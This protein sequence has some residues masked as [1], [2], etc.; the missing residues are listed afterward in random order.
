[1]FGVSASKGKEELALVFDI[2]SSS[3]GGALFYRE[4]TKIPKI[5]F[6]VRESIPI[7]KEMD[8][9]AFLLS[10]VKSLDNVA[11]KICSKGLG[12]P[13][14]VFCVLSSPWHVSQTRVIH[15][16]K[17]T[18][19]NFTT[20]LAD[21]L[22]EKEIKLFESEH[23]EKYMETG[24]KIRPIELKNMQTTLNGY[25]T[26]NPLGQKASTLSM[27]LFVSMSPEQFLSKIEEAIDRHFSHLTIK[28]SSFAMAAFTVTRD[29]FVNQPNFLLVDIGGEL[30]DISMTKK[31]IL[32][33]SIS[34][35]IGINFII[36]GVSLGLSI[37]LD[38]AQ[39]MLSIFK[40]GHATAAVEEKLKPV[41]DKLKIEWLKKFQESLVNMSNDISIP[42][43]IFM[44]TD[45]EWAD[46]FSEIIK[47]EQFNQ[48]TLTE[49][50]FQ[51]TFLGTEALHGA[52]QFSDEVN[53]DTCTIMESIYIN[54]YLA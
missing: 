23:L 46:F 11:S 5:I 48:Y 35:P 9:D 34:F 19:F 12:A 1:M 53:R 43:T 52:S 2:G 16:E 28:F 15:Y 6:S 45:K 8:I 26:S 54:R 36:R 29:L 24:S 25:P 32:L 22:T 10:T 30:T 27:A 17:N 38:E 50:K 42:S 47:N 44:T 13:S 18:V 51:I 31:D 4:P 3:V 14:R 33:G 7:Q 20:E 40:D 21:S 41:L 37:S 49:S 39:S